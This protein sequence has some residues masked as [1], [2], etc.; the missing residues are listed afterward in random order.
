MLEGLLKLHSPKI[1][2][3]VMMALHL[4]LCNSRTIV[5][6]HYPFTDCYEQWHSLILYLQ[7]IEA[8]EKSCDCEFILLCMAS[9]W[10]VHTE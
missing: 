3:W 4:D 5:D 9:I 10:T 8:G 7:E 1:Y 2:S 6:I